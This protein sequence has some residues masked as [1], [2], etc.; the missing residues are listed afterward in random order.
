MK[1]RLDQHKDFKKIFA[2]ASYKNWA[3]GLISM[4]CVLAV[5]RTIVLYPGSVW[6]LAAFHFA[7][8]ALVMSAWP[9]PRTDAYFFL[10]GFLFLGFW[11]KF[12]IH[13]NFPYPFLEPIGAFDASPH[14]WDQALS[15]ATVAAV[16]SAL[17]RIVY[18]LI[19]RRRLPYLRQ[20]TAANIVPPA[21]YLRHPGKVWGSTIALAL[22]LYTANYFFAFFQ[23][24]V[25]PLLVLPFGMNAVLA[26]SSFC[27][28]ALVFALLA[29][30]EMTRRPEHF[31][32]LVWSVCLVGI[33]ASVSLA[34]RAISILLF[35]AYAT[36]LGMHFPLVGKKLLAS[37]R[38]RLPLIMIASLMLGLI[39]VSSFRLNRYLV[40][41]DKVASAGLGQQGKIVAQTAPLP[42]ISRGSA[43]VTPVEIPTPSTRP[44]GT[45]RSDATPSEMFKQVMQLSVDRWIGLEGMLAVTGSPERGAVLL[46]AG[47]RESPSKGV[48]SI[49]QKISS[50]K[51]S[52]QPGFTYLTLP[53]APAILFYSG[54][55]I[56]V[57]VGMFFFAGMLTFIENFGMRMTGNRFVGSVLGIF[58][59]NAICQMNFPYL[60]MIFM[61]ETVIALGVIGA[62]RSWS[63]N[64]SAY[65]D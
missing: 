30:W 61:V 6:I 17:F 15:A 24:G 11:A 33:V 14:Q 3:I 58:M 55:L 19:A 54:S 39:L 51:Y 52:F 2:R 45:S 7:F 44:I 50:S 63:D 37:W 12:T 21:W 8:L 10:A 35:A 32:P 53:G 57:L 23:T 16:G 9:R 34:S 64:I 47:L 62:L 49:Y 13:L 20:E 36:A 26:W 43:P 48:D 40:P 4:L 29:G 60:W 25:N 42:S 18:L 5:G 27:G 28:A 41:E 65:R 59:A 38:W 22:M 56:L 31:A 1:T 46:A